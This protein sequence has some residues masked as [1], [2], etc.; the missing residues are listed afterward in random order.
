MFIIATRGA[1]HQQCMFRFVAE[2]LFW[3]WGL[4]SPRMLGG[5]TWPSH[6]VHGYR[7]A[8]GGG[9]ALLGSVGLSIGASGGV[10]GDAG[11]GGGPDGDT[12][13]R[14]ERLVADLA[15]EVGR[16]REELGRL[17]SKL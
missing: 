6:P 16:L 3:L 15:G 10:S 12:A 9:S 1:E 17:S 8:E 11:R 5:P 2:K 7:A 13:E 14:L 4:P